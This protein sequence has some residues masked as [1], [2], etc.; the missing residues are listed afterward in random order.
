[1]KRCVVFVIVLM[2]LLKVSSAFATHIRSVDIVVKAMNSSR[3]YDI[4]VIIYR[5]TQSNS[6]AG[7]FGRVYF[8]DNIDSAIYV[9]DPSP[10]IVSRPDL[11]PNI[12]TVTFNFR[13]RYQIHGTYQITYIEGDRSSNIRNIPGSDEIKYMTYVK[14]STREPS[15]NHFPVLTISPVDRACVFNTFTHNPGVVDDDGDLITYELAKPSSGVDQEIPGYISPISSQFYL[16]F[17]K[18]NEQETGP[19]TFDIDPLTGQLT[20]DAPGMIGEYSIAFKIFEWRK[21]EL[22]DEYELLSTTVRDM[23]IIVDD[24]LNMRPTL[25]TPENLCVFPGTKIER[26]IFGR[27]PE[28][29]EL[30][31]EASSSVFSLPADQSPATYLPF[32]PAYRMID[33]VKKY[34]SI[35]FLWNTTCGHI[36]TQPYQVVFQASDNPPHETELVT[37]KTW[38]IKVMAPAPVWKSAKLDLARREARLSWAPYTFCSATKIQVWRRVDSYPYTPGACDIG[39]PKTL[40]FDLIG[41]VNGNDTVFVDN[42]KGRK[43]ADGAQYCYRVVAVFT[44]VGITPS[45]TSTEVCLEPIMTDAPVITHVSV[46]ETDKRNGKI[47][48][49]WRSPFEISKTQFPEPY[50]YHIYRQYGFDSELAM[51]EVA[52]VSNDTTFLDESLNT[53]DSTFHY[54]IILYAKPKDHDFFTEVDTSAKASSERLTLFP[55]TDKITLQWRDS[56]PWS[57]VVNTRPWHLIYRKKHNDDNFTK[58]DS[59]NVSEDGFV[60]VDESVEPSEFYSYKV[61]TRGTYGN[62][63]IALLENHSQIASAYPDNDLLPCQPVLTV[64]KTDCDQYLSMQNCNQS[65]FENEFHW[66]LNKSTGCRVDVDYFKVYASSTEGGEFALIDGNFLDTLFTDTNLS[67]YARCYRVSMVDLSGEEG[68]L[69]EIQ[70]ND[71]CRN[72]ELPNVFT[73]NGD[74]CNDVFSTYYQGEAESECKPINVEW[75]PRFV[76]AVDFSVFNRWGTEVYHYDS[77]NGRPPQI[78]WDGR[79]QSREEVDAGTYFYQVSVTFNMLDPTKK[80]ENFKGWVRVVR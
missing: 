74:G 38:T 66:H 15:E 39:I 50:D 30:K 64:D 73:P 36:R 28:N 62:P 70:C 45:M 67:S 76:E 51:E 3:Q 42:N 55:E 21:N 16:V 48:V 41:E 26:T 80:R 49:R 68:P 46:E 47:R 23:Q 58:Y 60:Y 6:P 72:F 19:P 37:F 1:M 78:Y 18:G 77:R 2:A 63:L 52:I 56:V 32:P 8:G 61:L 35:N 5:N 53:Q 44:N 24:C 22:T 11:G 33:P 40:D 57:N 27:D 20:W 4:S 25:Q 71:N 65:A 14:F 13:H 43:L 9:L 34:D 7:A 17:A 10:T 54:K 75:C 69:S 79:N 12:E 29:K 59:V 31:L